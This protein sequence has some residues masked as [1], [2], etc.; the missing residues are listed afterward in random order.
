MIL[1]YFASGEVVKFSA[2]EIVRGAGEGPVVVGGIVVAV[3]LAV[4]DTKLSPRG[5]TRMFAIKKR[6]TTKVV[7]FGGK[8]FP[9]APGF[10]R[11]G[12]VLTGV[13]LS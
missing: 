3:G 11:S 9:S 13:S 6:A 2:A 12:Q 1:L 7:A 4:E 10:A 8:R 5:F